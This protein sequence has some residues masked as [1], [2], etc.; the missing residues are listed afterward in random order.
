MSGGLSVLKRN[1]FRGN[2]RK[3]IALLLIIVLFS[4]ISF[5]FLSSQLS[6]STDWSV[7]ITASISIYSADNIFGVKAGATNGFDP[8]FDQLAPPDP[9]AGISSCF[10]YSTNPSS[11]INEQKLSTS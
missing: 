6:A 9:P 8:A 4:L 2:N 7:K 11:P 1:D 5:S 3:V 10:F